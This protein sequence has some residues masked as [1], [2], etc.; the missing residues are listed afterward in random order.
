MYKDI[1]KLG[2][3]ETHCF[4]AQQIKI[5]AL[6]LETN[7]PLY[8]VGSKRNQELRW[9]QMIQ[10][11][12]RHC[13]TTACH[14]MRK[15]ELVEVARN[16]GSLRRDSTSIVYIG[17]KLGNTGNLQKICKFKIFHEIGHAGHGHGHPLFTGFLELLKG[18]TNNSENPGCNAKIYMVLKPLKWVCCT[19]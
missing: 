14:H 11:W 15:E 1:M 19:A 17:H 16:T 18:G 13:L 3:I 4:H 5:S 6:Q 8:A 10:N 9:Y 12:N 2:H 7:L